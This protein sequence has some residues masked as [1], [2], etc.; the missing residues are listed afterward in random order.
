MPFLSIIT[1]C[2][3]SEK[4]IQDTL[5]S[6]LGQSF[7][8]YEYLLIDGASQD[9]TVGIIQKYEPC[10]KGR[11]H[12]ISEPDGGIY[13]AMNKGLDRAVGEYVG[14]INSDDRYLPGAFAKVHE[15]AD[16][17]AE[18][19]DVIFSDMDYVNAEGCVVRSVVGDVSKLWKGMFVNHP[20]CFV[21]REAYERH[22]HFDTRFRIVAD[23]DLMQRIAHEGGR[24]LKS[25]VKLAE[26]HTGG[27]SD[28]SYASELEKHK[29]QKRYY[30]PF[31][32]GYCV[33]RSYGSCRL[34]PF[35]RK[36]LHG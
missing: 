8:D 17:S 1:V 24:F 30:S 21:S 34:L 13:E 9:G 22:G 3:N 20:T 4:T 15:L 26:F 31:R 35:L 36:K 12:W 27:V 2:Y 6:V 7:Q 5:E 25:D 18:K 33:L 19:P 29:V 14:I 16:T 11:M 32:Y 10:F 23:Y 28:S